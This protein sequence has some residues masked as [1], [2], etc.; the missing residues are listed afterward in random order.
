MKKLNGKDLFFMAMGATIGAGIITN[1]G[2]AIGMAGSG[3]IIAYL[4][5]FFVMFVANLPTMFFATVHPVMSPAYV[6]TSWVSKKTAGFWLYCQIFAAFAQAYMG[7]AFGTYVS[8]IFTG[9]STKAAACIIVTVFFLLNLLE[10]KTSAKVQNITTAVLLAVLLSF[11]ILGLPKCDLGQLFSSENLLYGGVRGIFDAC[12]SVLFGV[13]GCTILVNFGPQIEN[14]K[15][16]IP[17]MTIIT[18]FCAFLAFGLVAF[19]GSG[20]APIAEIAGKPMTVQA[21]I[22]YPGNGYLIFVIGGALLAII[23]TIN[24]N[25]QRYWSSII[26][27]VDEGWLPEFMGKRNNHGIPWV[28]MVLFWLMALIPNLFGLNIGQ[29]VSLASAV[30]LIPMLIPIWG[31][32]KLPEGDPDGWK[33]SKLSGYFSSSASRVVFCAFC[34]ALIGIF[35]VLNVLNFTKLA[36]IFVA[37]YFIVALIICFGFGDK[38]MASGAKRVAA[39]IEE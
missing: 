36:A 30:T 29:L 4:I 13:G 33:E 16:N 2:V 21:Q 38:L 10:L 26:R 18:F 22:I 12:A 8:S 6:M 32:L 15:R 37:V 11:I 25:Y 7:V 27:G 19:V 31:F 20:V 39:K 24:S 14:P 35:V 17:R 34:T 1:T 28:L 5:A 3:V 23:T 9:I